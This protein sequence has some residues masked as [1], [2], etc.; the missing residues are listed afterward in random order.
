MSKRRERQTLADGHATAS[1]F[2]WLVQLGAA[3]AAPRE[4]SA[5]AT[6]AV[7]ILA[8]VFDRVVLWEALEPDSL[9]LTELSGAP[10]VIV[11]DASPAQVAGLRLL[12]S[13]GFGGAFARLT[14]QGGRGS[15]AAALAD[16][17]SPAGRAQATAQP[18][19]VG[20]PSHPNDGPSLPEDWRNMARREGI[21]AG[22]AVPLLADSTPVGVLECYTT[23]AVADPDTTLTLVHIAAGQ[24]ALAFSQAA[25]QERV[26]RRLAEALLLREVSQM[27]SNSI[28]LEDTLA[29]VLAS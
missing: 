2:E 9:T 11:D 22:W 27:I 15:R 3:L 25:V 21:S 10:G 4:A 24:L 5:I 29:A 6:A 26:G 20:D 23:D 14:G 7:D 18:I 8:G 17:E 1:S 13:R 19:T 12:A 16:P 28:D